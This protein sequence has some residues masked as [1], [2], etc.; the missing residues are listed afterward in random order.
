MIRVHDSHEPGTSCTIGWGFGM[1]GVRM[2]SEPT[3]NNSGGLVLWA[4]RK[5]LNG[6]MLRRVSVDTDEA[7]HFILIPL[8]S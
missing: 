6:V 7:G 1:D 3:N 5:M 2:I 8:Q 4:Q